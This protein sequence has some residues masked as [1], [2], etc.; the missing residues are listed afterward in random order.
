[1]D[2]SMLVVPSLPLTDEHSLSTSR[3]WHEQQWIEDDE[4]LEMECINNN[5]GHDP[6]NLWVEMNGSP[7]KSTT[8]NRLFVAMILAAA[9]FRIR[10]I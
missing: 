10:S 7:N 9:V 1:M 2:A 3:E 8:S 4:R 6:S 5:G